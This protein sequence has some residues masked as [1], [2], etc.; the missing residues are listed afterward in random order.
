LVDK[1]QG[2]SYRWWQPLEK[3]QQGFLLKE[4][5]SIEEALRNSFQNKN[6]YVIKPVESSLGASVPSQFQ[7][8]KIAGEDAQFF[9]QYF[10]APVL[11]DGQVLFGKEDHGGNYNIEIRMTATQVSNSRPIADVSRRFVT[12]AGSFETSVDKKMREVL[13]GTA[14]DLSSQVLEAWQRGS[15]GTSVIRLTIHGN[16]EL[17]VMEGLKEKIRTQITQVKNIRERLVADESISY[18][19]DT[20]VSAAELAQKIEALDFNG[21]KLSKVSEGRDEVVLKFSQ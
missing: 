11:I 6:F 15:L 9:A 19:V 1:V 3:N 12:D 5:R 7:N 17:P 2:R 16:Q 4:G 10:N 21:K 14:N 8:E 13:E 20:A 18:E